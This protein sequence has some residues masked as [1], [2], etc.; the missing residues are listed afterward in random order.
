MIYLIEAWI[1]KKNKGS[2]LEEDAGFEI[3]YLDED[4]LIEIM[5]LQEVI[6]M[7]LWSN[8]SFSILLAVRTVAL[9]PSYPSASFSPCEAA[10]SRYASLCPRAGHWSPASFSR[11]AGMRIGGEYGRRARDRPEQLSYEGDSL[12]LQ[13]WPDAQLLRLGPDGW[14]EIPQAD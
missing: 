1:I 5:A 12:Q 2:P 6:V 4:R 11:G 8:L 3:R 9:P 13:I 10:N 14:S 7:L